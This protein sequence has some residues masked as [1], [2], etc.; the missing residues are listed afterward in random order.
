MT[1]GEDTHGCD[2]FTS[3]FLLPQLCNS[4][5]SPSASIHFKSEQGPQGASEAAL[6]KGP[7]HCGIPRGVLWLW[8]MTEENF[9]GCPR[10]PVKEKPCSS[11][12][13]TTRTWL[14]PATLSAVRPRTRPW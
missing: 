2:Y 14:R 13:S 1:T 6:F 11:S 3:L 10:F 7:H 4:T 5:L 12:A 9:P 8:C